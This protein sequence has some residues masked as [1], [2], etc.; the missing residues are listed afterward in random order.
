MRNVKGKPVPTT[1]SGT[2]D[3]LGVN[4]I[5]G[6]PLRESTSCGDPDCEFRLSNCMVPW[7]DVELGV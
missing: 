4:D 3:A 7:G 6:C 1:F 2:A 5:F